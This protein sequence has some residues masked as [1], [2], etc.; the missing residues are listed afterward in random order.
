MSRD[1]DIIVSIAAAVG[2]LGFL[3]AIV[4]T[5]VSLGALLLLPFLS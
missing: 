2:Y 1:R 5:C 4:L 3:V